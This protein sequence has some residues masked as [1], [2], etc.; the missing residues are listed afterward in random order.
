MNLLSRAEI[1][2]LYYRGSVLWRLFL[3]RMYGHFPGTKWT[4]RIREVSVRRGSTVLVT[5]SQGASLRIEVEWREGFSSLFP[6]P[7]R[8]IRTSNYMDM[9][10]CGVWCSRKFLFEFTSYDLWN[11]G[12]NKMFVSIM[13]NILLSLEVSKIVQKNVFLWAKYV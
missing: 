12:R 9:W 6:I 7:P 5:G 1:S 2:C 10:L 8:S 4:V 13:N 3:Q 11:D